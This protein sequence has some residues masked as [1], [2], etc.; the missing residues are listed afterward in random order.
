MYPIYHSQSNLKSL[1][2]EFI[3]SRKKIPDNLLDHLNAVNQHKAT[4]LKSK[5]VI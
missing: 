5:T 1:H 3:T 2:Y 4:I